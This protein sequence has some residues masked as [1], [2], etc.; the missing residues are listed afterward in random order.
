MLCPTC[1]QAMVIL[2]LQ[3][4][5]IDHCI[6]CGGIWL[7]SGEL[8]NLLKGLNNKDTLLS[9]LKNKSSSSEPLKKCPNCYKKM[10]LVSFRSLSEEMVVDKRVQNCGL[11]FDRHELFKL[12]EMGG[13]DNDNQ[14]SI[15]N[16]LSN[17]FKKG[18]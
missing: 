18:V 8:E 17:I 5:E 4:I 13:S 2:E 15:Q 12:I 7:D 16:L 10:Q 6:T 14:N 9:S 1:R 3:D 11:W